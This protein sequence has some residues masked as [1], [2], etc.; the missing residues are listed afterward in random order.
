MIP[1]CH[2]L[3]TLREMLYEASSRLANSPRAFAN[4][5][6]ELERF[7]DEGLVSARVEHEIVSLYVLAE[8]TGA[9]SPSAPSR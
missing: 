9:S 8:L 7:V 2:S 3:S 1:A 4:R 6:S 5:I